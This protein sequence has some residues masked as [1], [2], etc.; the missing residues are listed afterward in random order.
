MAETLP[1]TWKLN[2][3]RDQNEQLNDLKYYKTLNEVDVNCRNTKLMFWNEVSM[4]FAVVIALAFL[5]FANKTWK[6]RYFVEI[7]AWYIEKE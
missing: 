2:S 3:H 7:T 5:T 6:K 4:I 1:N